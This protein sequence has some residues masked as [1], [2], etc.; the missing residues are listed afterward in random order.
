MQVCG[1][2]TP[3]AAAAA[4]QLELFSPTSTKM[5]LS[6]GPPVGIHPGLG[7][8]KST[9][10]ARY[11]TELLE[12]LTTLSS[13]DGRLLYLAY[14]PLSK[15]CVW[16]QG[17]LVALQL[18]HGNYTAP[19]QGE[20]VS[21]G[22]SRVQKQCISLAPGERVVKLLVAGGQLPEGLTMTTTTGRVASVGNATRSGNSTS[23]LT[24]SKEFA[25]PPGGHLAG[26]SG[27]LLKVG[28]GDG[29]GWYDALCGL[30]VE[31]VV[32]SS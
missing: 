24:F 20:F 16:Q 23:G 29:N 4:E 5:H 28:Y 2:T 22:S 11:S 10:H 25:G 31:W 21:G 8:A 19:T 13:F 32:G 3:A 6:Q 14:G 7:A 17:W 12:V 15:L 18:V 26:L 27:W 30:R 1:G 9:P